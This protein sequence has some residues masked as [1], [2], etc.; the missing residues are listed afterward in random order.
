MTTFQQIH[1]PQN[2]INKIIIDPS[3]VF[4]FY[5]VGQCGPKSDWISTI[6]DAAKI[7]DQDGG[8]FIEVIFPPMIKD[9]YALVK[10]LER[11]AN[12]SFFYCVSKSNVG[13]G[14]SAEDMFYRLQRIV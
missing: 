4:V 13:F 11:I 14:D 7:L 10:R 12:K 8:P 3:Q 5:G 6:K 2:Q 9:K 1:D